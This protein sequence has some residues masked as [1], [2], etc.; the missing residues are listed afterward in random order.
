MTLFGGVAD[1]NYRMKINFE[2]LEQVRIDHLRIGNETVK[3]QIVRH[4]AC[5]KCDRTDHIKSHRLKI[6]ENVKNNE[7]GA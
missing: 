1:G 4:K 3:I 6:S 7:V 5:Y 2:K